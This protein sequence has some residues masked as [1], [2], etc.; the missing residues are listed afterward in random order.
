MTII[1]FSGHNASGK[2]AVSKALAKKLGFSWWGMADITR[3][4]AKKLGMSISEHDEYVAKNPEVDLAIDQELKHLSSRSNIVVDARAGWYF[5]PESI[6]VFV[7]ADEDV[8][9]KRAFQNPRAQEEYSSLQEAKQ[10]LAKRIE[11]FGSRLKKLY[12]IDVYDPA[13]FDIVIDTTNLTVQENVS[14]IIQ[15]AQ[16]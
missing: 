9:A 5:L 4:H 13:N 6:K 11:V 10:G 3:S 15:K 2:T 1:T 12:G 14:E 8:R 7:T 16:L